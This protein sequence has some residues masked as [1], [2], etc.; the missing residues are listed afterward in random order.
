MITEK[1]LRQI[2]KEAYGPHTYWHE[3]EKTFFALWRVARAAQDY[4]KELRGPNTDG[5]RIFSLR[6][7]LFD[8]LES[9]PKKAK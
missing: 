8:C 4:E 1:R 7:R 2:A 3:I 5:V 9:L 6:D